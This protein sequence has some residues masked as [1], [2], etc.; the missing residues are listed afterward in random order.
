MGI[1]S[2][3]FRG[4]KTPPCR[5]TSTVSTS[6]TNLDTRASCA[7]VSSTNLNVLREGSPRTLIL[8]RTTGR[9]LMPRNGAI[10]F[11]GLIGKLDVLHVHCPKCSR[12]GRYRVQH[13]IKQRGRNA[14]LIDRL[15]EI[16]A[17]CPN[18]LAHN[19]NDPCGG[20]FPDLPRV[21]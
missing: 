19:M 18:K 5:T 20:R 2:S 15:D 8:A 6:T 4:L 11:A 12:A 10:I 9:I 13:L 1:K 16:T 17:D 14:K 7:L 21:L 3:M